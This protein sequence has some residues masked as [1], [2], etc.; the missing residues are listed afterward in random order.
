MQFR[1]ILMSAALLLIVSG[2][3]APQS[4]FTPQSQAAEPE[5]NPKIE[6]GRYIANDVA[7]CV[8]CHSPRTINGQII[9]TEVF[10]GAPIP[11]PSPF[12]EQEWAVKA[13]NLRSVAE[14]WGEEDLA[15]FLQTGIPPRGIAPRM[16]MPPFRMNAEDAAAVAAYLKSL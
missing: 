4:E 11:V 10:L 6:R 15:K 7:M 16:P 2:L 1:R 13:P 14:I 3:S 5:K 12:P 9:R 8:L